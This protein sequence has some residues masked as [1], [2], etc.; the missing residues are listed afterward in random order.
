MVN[1]WLLI[2]ALMLTIVGYCFMLVAI[3]EL[4]DR[5]FKL[6]K[7]LLDSVKNQKDLS[8]IMKNMHNEIFKP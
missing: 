7:M 4:E 2:I 3:K 8:E 5:V 1:G 6:Q